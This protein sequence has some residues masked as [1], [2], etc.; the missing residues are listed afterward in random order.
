M[1]EYEI[2]NISIPVKK[3]YDQGLEESIKEEIHCRLGTTD[4]M[5]KGILKKSMDARRKDS[6]CYNI[7]ALVSIDGIPLENSGVI[8]YEKYKYTPLALGKEKLERRPVVIGSGPCGLFCAYILSLNG[9][10]P[11][12]LERGCEIRERQ[13][14]V[15]AFW[16]GS[17]LDE[18]TNVQ[19]G[20]GG[21]GTFSDGKLVTRISDPRSRFVL[22]KMAEAGA[23]DRILFEAK[24]H[25]GTDRL[26]AVI[27]NI[28]ED[29][30]K[31]GGMF[32]FNTVATDIHLKNG[33]VRAIEIN[34]ETEIEADIVIAATGHSSR[35]TYEMFLKRGITMEQKP[36]SAGLRIEH[37]QK[38]VNLSQ[39]G[40]DSQYITEAAE[41]S[42]NHK[43][44][45]R[46]VYTFCMCPG[47]VVVNASS[48]KNMLTVNGMSYSNRSGR[49]ANS[50]WVAEIRRP[51]FPSSHPL[52]GIELQRQIEKAAY[53]AGGGKG[54]APVQQLADFISGK[55]S[56]SF[57]RIKPSFTGETAMAD[58]NEV[59]PGYISKAL[60][61]SLKGFSARLPFFKA[62]DAILTGCETRTSSPIRMRRD[63]TM[64]S[65]GTMGFF[66]AGEGAGYAGGIMSAAVDGIKVAEEI[67]KRYNYLG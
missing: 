46:N 25:I 56:V 34:G 19:F 53:R 40:R 10:K 52:A 12:I 30:K 61:T 44:K 43:M 63:I 17:P 9:F 64:Q 5:Y 51:D 4:F 60:K 13:K 3:V 65:E 27:E 35:D 67:V 15:N 36:F 45:E 20:E 7:S 58:L 21:A 39:W 23:D 6:I 11:L 29:I 24:P 37:I 62:S 33:R 2:R 57:G 18:N 1:N 22:E 32:L 41:Y 31:L 50:A 66:P 42:A 55:K 59:L 16:K 38:D 28:R 47:G 14:K 49:N 48:E 26:T 8:T 54:Y